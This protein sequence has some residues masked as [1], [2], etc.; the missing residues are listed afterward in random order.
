VRGLSIRYTVLSSG[1]EQLWFP[2]ALWVLFAIMALVVYGSDRL[3]VTARAYLGCAVP[4]TAGVLAAYSVL[5]DAALELRFAAPI[6]AWRT[7]LERL[8][9]ALA[10]E[11]VC[12]GAFQGLVVA[13]GG[14][15]S[16]LGNWGAVQLAWLVPCLALMSV[17]GVGALAGRRP[18]TGALIVGLIWL[19]ELIARGSFA[20]SDWARYLLIFMGALIPDH[21]ALR[22]NQWTLLALCGALFVA[23]S[24]LL[25]R[26]E[27]YL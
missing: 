18:A 13:M 15:L 12:A 27:R 9:L 19:V 16:I 17:G 8:G 3:L 23:A 20:R 25:R 7:L 24:L 26:Q 10:V 4:L 22:A 11:A 6:P 14:D 5:G 2:A 1:L 21:P